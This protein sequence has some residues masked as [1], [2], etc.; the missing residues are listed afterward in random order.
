MLGD[1][2]ILLVKF[3][4]EIE[5]HRALNN[6]NDSYSKYNEIAREGILVGLRRYRFFGESYTA[7]IWRMLNF[8]FSLF[9][10]TSK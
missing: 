2:N 10:F 6:L 3:A 5:G 9:Q 8:E 1:D 4:E 7:L